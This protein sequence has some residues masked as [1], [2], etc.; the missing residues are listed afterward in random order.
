MMKVQQIYIQSIKI[1]IILK[2]ILMELSFYPQ[3]LNSLKIIIDEILLEINKKKNKDINIVFNLIINNNFEKIINFTKEIKFIKNICIYCHD[4]K[5]YN[6]LKNKYNNIFD[7]YINKLDIVNFINNNSSSSIYPYPLK[8]AIS[9]KEYKNKY[10]DLHIGVSEFYGNLSPQFFDIYFEKM[11]KL[12]EN[13]ERNEDLYCKKNKLLKAFLSFELKEDLNSK[14]EKIINEFSGEMYT[15]LNR[16]L[17]NSKMKSDS[18]IAYFTA[19]LMLSLNS[20]A[21]KNNKYCN[22]NEKLYYRGMKIPFSSLLQYERAKGR[23]ITSL[24]FISTN[25]DESLV[26]NFANHYNK[27]PMFSVIF[28]IENLYEKNWIQSGIDI[29]LASYFSEEKEYVF[30]PFSFFLVKNVKIDINEYKGEIFLQSLGKT[31][32]FE[33]KLTNE[34]DIEYNNAKKI[35]EIKEI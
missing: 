8:K 22:I 13:D 34:N 27:K 23:I 30:L 18:T 12:I 33:E 24:S 17:R 7:I 19:R 3:N 5:E 20:Y 6:D 9:L 31:E 16:W 1:A 25:E 29:S 35:M 28:I 11:K 14:D 10:R 15:D 21:I 26:R 4:L 32:I 2:I